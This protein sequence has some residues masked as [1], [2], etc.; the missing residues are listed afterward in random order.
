MLPC[1]LASPHA[2]EGDRQVERHPRRSVAR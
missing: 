2:D 1:T